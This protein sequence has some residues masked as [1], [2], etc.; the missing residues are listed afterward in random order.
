MTLADLIKAFRVE[1]QDKVAPFIFDDDDV[2][3][4]L[5]EAEREA[6]VRGRLL[7]EEG[8]SRICEIALAAG[9]NTYKLHPALYEI[10][11]IEFLSMTDAGPTREPIKLVSR[12]WLDNHV[13][14]WRVKV[15]PPQFAVQDDTTIRFV[16]SPFTGGTMFLSGYRLPLRGLT[17]DKGSTPEIHEAH[18]H[19]LV[20]WALFK[21]FS[22]PDNDTLNLGSAAAALEKFTRY[23]GLQ[24]DSDLRRHTREDLDH[25]VN[26]FWP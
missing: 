3:R 4:W 6:A 7:H 17:K 23:F 26:A 20:D 13:R 21:A 8:N 14:D 12:T 5:I 2:A 15:D 19:H 24:T 11:R 22:L 25:H 18:H 9:V 10:D 1:T 16:P